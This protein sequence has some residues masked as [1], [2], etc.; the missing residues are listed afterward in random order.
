VGEEAAQRARVQP[1]AAGGQEERVVRAPRQLRPRLAQV[2]RDDVRGFL[3]QRHDPL[4]AALAAHTHVLL[5]EVD[6][7]EVEPDRLRA[8][9]AR[10][11]D[12]LDE[13]AVAKAERAVAVDR[14]DQLLDLLPLRRL[15]QPLGLLRGQ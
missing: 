4:L 11:V 7:G 1:P 10:R 8:A 12:E 2:A 6:V 14:V 5:L 13:G 15:W 3:A 9:Q